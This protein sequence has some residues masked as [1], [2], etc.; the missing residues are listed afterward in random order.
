VL[1]AGDKYG[2]VYFIS[3][4]MEAHWDKLLEVVQKNRHKPSGARR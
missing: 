1:T 4:S 3:D 2:K